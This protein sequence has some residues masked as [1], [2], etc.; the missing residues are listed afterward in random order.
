MTDLEII[1]VILSVIVFC[2]I[3]HFLIFMFTFQPVLMYHRVD[4]R[5]RPNEIRYINHKNKKLDLDQMKMK[6]SDFKAQMTYLKKKGYQTVHELTGHRKQVIITFDDGY[7]D[8]YLN[9]YPILKELGFHGIFFVTT[10]YISNQLLME[11]DKDDELAYNKMM[12]YDEL[13]EM[14]S[15]HMVIGSHTK[16]HFWLTGLDETLL[17]DEIVQS[18]K[19]L[20]EKLGTHIETFAYPAGMYDQNTLDTV[21][22]TYKSAYVTSRGSDLKLF[23]KD[24]YQIERETISRDDSMLMFKLKVWGIHRYLRKFWTVVLFKKVISWLK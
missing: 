11:V 18:K 13:K 4:D 3:V 1:L 19:L 24:P 9:A 17:N 10:N 20:E 8:N 22:K 12:T 7:E 5:L 23:Q 15:G 6:V 16:S 21:K 14:I 2:H